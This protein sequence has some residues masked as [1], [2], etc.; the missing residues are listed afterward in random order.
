MLLLNRRD[1]TRGAIGAVAGQRAVVR[2]R[3][4]GEPVAGSVGGHVF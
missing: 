4:T 2:H 1:H 3:R